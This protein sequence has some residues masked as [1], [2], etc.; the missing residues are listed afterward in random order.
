MQQRLTSLACGFVLTLL[1]SLP[2]AAGGPQTLADC[3]RDGGR[4]WAQLLAL[5]PSCALLVEPISI[6][7]CLAI[8]L[9]GVTIG[10]LLGLYD[11]TDCAGAVFKGKKNGDTW[12]YTAWNRESAKEAVRDARANCRRDGARGCVEVIRFRFAAAG[13]SKPGRDVV[14]AQAGDIATARE[15]ARQRCASSSG[16]GRC[17]FFASYANDN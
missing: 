8:Y 7:I 11:T 2:A 17:K 13:Y 16:G 6:A 3:G 14:W 5:A 12:H 4:T 1:V 10:E 9:P 15:L